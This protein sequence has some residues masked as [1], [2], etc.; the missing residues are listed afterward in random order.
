[1]AAANVSNEKRIFDIKSQLKDGAKNFLLSEDISDE[2]RIGSKTWKELK[3]EVC[4]SQEY[5]KAPWFIELTEH[6]QALIKDLKLIQLQLGVSVEIEPQ[7]NSI[8]AKFIEERIEDLLPSENFFFFKIHYGETED[9]KRRNSIEK[10]EILRLIDAHMSYD[11][12]YLKEGEL[13]AQH[14]IDHEKRILLDGME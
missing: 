14:L 3:S 7:R 12:Y 10:R 4:S 1:M 2:T 9:A 11:K 6:E 5:K 8:R 13:E